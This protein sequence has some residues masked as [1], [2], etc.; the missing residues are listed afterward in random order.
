MLQRGGPSSAVSKV[1]PS[2]DAVPLDPSSVP[3]GPGIGIA[4][5]S[6][7]NFESKTLICVC[8]KKIEVYIKKILTNSSLIF[9]PEGLHKLREVF[10][11]IRQLTALPFLQPEQIEEN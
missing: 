9:I 7:S 4:G 2:M 11:F 6:C 8:R 3:I 5:K 1:T 10:S